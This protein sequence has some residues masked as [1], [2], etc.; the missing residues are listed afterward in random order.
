MLTYLDLE[1]TITINEDK[2]I[3]GIYISTFKK[4]EFKI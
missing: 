3:K 1:M 4:N 2:M